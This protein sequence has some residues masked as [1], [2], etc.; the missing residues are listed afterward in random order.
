ML[1]KDDEVA[2]ADALA[3]RKDSGCRWTRRHGGR[4]GAD[5][6]A[7]LDKL[8]VNTVAQCN[9]REKYTTMLTIAVVNYR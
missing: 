3:V 8:L 5:S 1:F 4:N 6:T 2:R 9:G 7:L